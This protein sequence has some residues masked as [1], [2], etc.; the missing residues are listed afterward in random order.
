MASA[1][2]RPTDHLIE[3]LLKEPHRFDFF[4]AV[5]LLERLRRD[6]AEVGGDASPGREAVRLRPSLG[7]E[8]PAATLAD[9]EDHR[10]DDDRPPFTLVSSFLGLY[11]LKGVLPWH[12]TQT[13]LDQERRKRPAAREFLDIFNH[14]WLSL[15]YRAWLKSRYPLRYRPDGRDEMT[16]WLLSLVGLGTRGL[17]GRSG[18]PD[19]SLLAWSGLFVAPRSAAG[20]RA[21]LADFLRMPVRVEPFA[22]EWVHIPPPDR[23]RLGSSGRNRGLGSSLVIGRRIWSRQHRFLVECGPL[24][25]RELLTLLPDGETFGRV[26]RLG[27]LYA[28]PDLAFSIR[29]RLADGETVTTRLGGPTARLGWTTWIGRSSR[30]G[31]P[32]SVTFSTDRQPGPEPTTMASSGS[33]TPKQQGNTE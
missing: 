2:G 27:R 19:A 17:R 18:V 22:G 24:R 33:S 20:L 4:Q 12:Y 23:N 8:F 16:G 7:F 1:S 28:G 30:T 11:G 5:R 26:V 32:R 15:F 13:L 25:A 31:A 6:L 14:R 21:M 9:A 29:L 10:P 3:T